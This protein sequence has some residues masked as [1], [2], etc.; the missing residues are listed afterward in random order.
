MTE[1]PFVRR[2][3][4]AALMAAA[5]L[6]QVGVAASQ[7]EPIP[8]QTQLE[9]VLGRKVT[10]PKG[11][12]GGRIVDVLID[13]AGQVHAFVVE[14]GGFLGIGT[15]KIA[16]ERSAFRFVEGKIMVD[17]SSEQVQAAREYSAGNQPS[18]VKV[19]VTSPD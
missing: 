13:P 19:E 1:L 7:P 6:S 8:A 9:S 15:R 5:L 16:V 17:V 14:F 4:G 18:V 10:P 3:A 11:V 2:C 12:E